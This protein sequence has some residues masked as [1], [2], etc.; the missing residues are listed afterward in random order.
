MIKTLIA[1]TGGACVV[2]LLSL[3]CFP[4]VSSSTATNKQAVI[5][6]LKRVGNDFAAFHYNTKG[7]VSEYFLV[8]ESDWNITQA[9]IDRIEYHEGKDVQMVASNGI[10][11]SFSLKDPASM[12][13]QLHIMDVAGIAHLKVLK[14]EG[15]PLKDAE[16]LA[17]ARAGGGPGST[18]PNCDKDCLSGGCGSTSCSRQ[19]AAGAMECSVSCDSGYFAC[20]GDIV[21]YG[22]HCLKN[23][24][25]K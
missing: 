14:S 4:S 18:S 20:C 5:F 21:S 1:T 2:I 19:V 23:T 6:E 11:Y 15:I 22:C 25:C 10:R 3:S 24:C 8:Q 7:N 12:S 13:A 16:K 9:S 17:F